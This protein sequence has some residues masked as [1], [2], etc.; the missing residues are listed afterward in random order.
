MKRIAISALVVALLVG[1]FAISG[2]QKTAV[3]SELQID[4]EG[5]NPW[6]HLRVNNAPESFHF[7]VM[8]DRTGGNRG[9]IFSQAVEQINL[10]QPTFVVC[11]G[12]LIQ[13][14]SKDSAILAREWKELQP[15]P[16]RLQMPFFYV[17]G[18]HDMANPVEASVWKE[19]FG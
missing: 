14:Y 9:R 8:S 2:G 5:R 11:V 7:V 1:A 4:V 13:G 10:L 3:K 6:T 12:D 19:R 16:S 15:Y 18:N 17:P